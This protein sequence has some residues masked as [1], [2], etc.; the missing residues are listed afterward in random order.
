MGAGKVLIIIG[1]IA[2]LAATFFLTFFYTLGDI[3]YSGLGFIFNIPDI[4]TD[5][6]SWALFIGEE[7]MMV[8]IVAIVFIV[9][10]ISGVLQLVGLA[11]RPVAIIGSIMPIVLGVLFLLIGFGILEDFGSYALLFMNDALVPGIVPFDID[12]GDVGLGAYI[13][14]AGGVLGLIGGIIGSSDW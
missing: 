5:A 7:V 9:F 11:S 8:Y 3:D 6:D 4:F 14:L 2:T 12:L 1:G 13:V 10:I